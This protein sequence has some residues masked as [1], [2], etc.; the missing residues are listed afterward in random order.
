[1]RRV[2]LRRT[3][4][5][6]DT[7]AQSTAREHSLFGRPYICID[8]TTQTLDE[9]S[10]ETVENAWKRPSSNPTNDPNGLRGAALVHFV[11]VW[12]ARGEEGH[13]GVCLELP[14]SGRS[15]PRYKT[16]IYITSS[17]PHLPKWAVFVRQKH[18][19]PSFDYKPLTD[20][21][22]SLWLRDTEDTGPDPST[23]TRQW[24]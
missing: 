23:L 24:M 17:D 20:S 3:G 8:R 22:C 1:M 14:S 19:R 5:V 11:A 15:I 9:L 6:Q 18:R 4:P 13:C 2:H 10:V 7:A 16:A 12:P 21:F